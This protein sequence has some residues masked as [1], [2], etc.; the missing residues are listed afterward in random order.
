VKK[1]KNKNPVRV[2]ATAKRKG[3]ILHPAK[4]IH[5]KT[6][7]R[8]ILKKS[9]GKSYPKDVILSFTRRHY[10]KFHPI[11]FRRMIEA[12]RRKRA[13]KN[14][15]KKLKRIYKYCVSLNPIS[16][17]FSRYNSASIY[18]LSDGSVL[19]KGNKPIKIPKIIPGRNDVIKNIIAKKGRALKLPGLAPINA[20]DTFIHRFSNKPKL[21]YLLDGSLLIKGNKPLWKIFDYKGE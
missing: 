12:G 5:C 9:P 7:G 17:H 8:I 4:I 3:Y 6:C 13:L 19:I 21:H 14:P 15:V 20:T 18:G 2:K 10:K 11:Q 1:R 16:P